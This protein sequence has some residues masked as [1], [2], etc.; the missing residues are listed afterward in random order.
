MTRRIKRYLA[1]DAYGD[2]RCTKTRPQARVGEWEEE[3]PDAPE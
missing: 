1:I 2:T 3:I